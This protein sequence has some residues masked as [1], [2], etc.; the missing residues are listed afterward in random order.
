MIRLPAV[1]GRFYSADPKE[2][3][4]NVRQLLD[5]GAQNSAVRAL[6]VP[7]A[8]YMYSGAVAGR[9]WGSVV[10]PETSNASVSFASTHGN[11]SSDFPG[12]PEF[13]RGARNRFTIGSGGANI[14][15]E[16]FGGRILFRRR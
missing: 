8:G 13:E 9:T 2:L 11:I 12:T 16:T 6:V 7:H 15:A 14:E 10:I 4:N 3:R 5:G 1:A